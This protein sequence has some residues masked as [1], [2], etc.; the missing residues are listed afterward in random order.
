M[1]SAAEVAV[2][3]GSEKSEKAFNFL[4]SAVATAFMTYFV[5]IN[6]WR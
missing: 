2:S 5:S 6:Y 3:C 1:G 4:A